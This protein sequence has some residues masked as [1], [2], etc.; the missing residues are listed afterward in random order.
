MRLTCPICGPRDLREFTYRGAAV[1]RPAADAPVGAWEGY[2][3]LRDN[4]AGV[5]REFWCHTG[6]CGAWMDVGR[7]T[8]S[9]AVV[10]VALSSG[11]LRE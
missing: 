1:S 10:G 11:A 4:P 9:H 2:L 5:A 3:H 6:G 8:R 7:D